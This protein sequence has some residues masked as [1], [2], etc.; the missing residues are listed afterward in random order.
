MRLH[1]LRAILRRDFLGYFSSP[2]GYVF[3]T[4]FIFLSAAA[5]FW[6]DRFFT[7]NLANLDT[8]NRVFPLLLL[9]L[10]PAITMSSWADEKR[11][12]VDELLL[13]LPARDVDLV[14]GKYLAALGIYTVALFFSLSHLVVLA[15]LGKPDL[16]L[17]LSNY[18]AYWLLGAALLA[19]GMV[20]S[21]LTDNLTVGFILGSALCA[22]PVFLDQAGSLLGGSFRSVEKLAAVPRFQEM[23]TGVVSMS[24]VLYFVALAATMFFVNLILVGRR[25]WRMP[26]MGAH[27]ATRALAV[28]VGAGSL[29]LL[30]GRAPVRADFTAERLHSLSDSTRKI[31]AG[32]DAENPVYIQA[33]VSRDVPRAYVE[34]RANLLNLLREYAAVGGKSI[35]LNVVETEK[36][37]DAS[38]DA[39][40]RFDIR[41]QTL[42]E[43]QGGRTENMDVFLGVAVTCAADEIVTPF[44]FKGLP[45][46][47]ELTRAI[48]VVSQKPKKAGEAPSAGGE[49]GKANRRRVG[50]LE[51]EAKVSGGFDFSSMQQNDEWE[52]VH[53]LRRQYEVVNVPATGPYP[54]DI[55]VLIAILPSSLTQPQ[56]ET[57]A[58]WIKKGKPTLIVDDPFPTEIPGGAASE[59]TKGGPRNPFQQGPP[60]EQ[61]GNIGEIMG[62]CG[63]RWDTTQ[64]AWDR[65]NPHPKLSLLDPEFVFIGQGN[66][67]RDAFNPQEVTTAGLQEI[68]CIFPGCIEMRGTPGVNFTPLLSTGKNSGTLPYPDVFTR[69]FMGGIS[70]NHRRK[71]VPADREFTL[72]ARLSGTVNAIFIADVDLIGGQFFALRRQG[73]EFLE[74]D[75]VT[76]FLNCVDQLAGDDSF[77]D[78]RKRRRKHRTLDKL[79][80]LTRTYTQQQMKDERDA[81][82]AAEKK[83]KEANDRLTAAVDEISKRTDLDDMTKR[84]MAEQKRQVE[85]KRLEEETKRVEDEKQAAIDASR[86]R[87]KAEIDR[88]QNRIKVLGTMLPPIPGL[89]LGVVMWFVRLRRERGMAAGDR[90]M[91]KK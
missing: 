66:G 79:E 59:K 78:L 34:T 51:T 9:F 49:G 48:R 7:D 55:S 40:E 73:H 69:N 8:L 37:T 68:V 72:A 62:I 45:I 27:A 2:T 38:R 52:F 56:M 80:E 36:Y 3:I 26:F 23:T 21:A 50:V 33:Y 13:T 67:A 89:I 70:L 74:L 12:G 90:W 86:S 53:E 4:V 20:G 42:T 17:M 11:Q 84:V 60:P 83:L 75:N 15:F 5:A 64:I 22:V 81:D 35:Q 16:G 54:D 65:Y 58:A 88:I 28:A 25:R 85:Q 10:V 82:D 24:G 61:K 32:I 47:Y 18:L 57:F 77:I 41:P 91:G 14:A 63:I 6:Q 43:D 39:Q 31:L 46:E 76:F 30:A 29:V 1:V 71:H 19:V 87:S 44:F